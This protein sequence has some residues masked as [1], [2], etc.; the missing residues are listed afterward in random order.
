ME[1]TGLDIAAAA[2]TYDGVRFRN[3]GR[4][5][6]TGV[7]C[8]GLLLAV[9]RGFGLLAEVPDYAY[10]RR[11][12]GRLLRQELNKYLDIV[13]DPRAGDV[14]LFADK[15]SLPN[16]IGILT[17]D[18]HGLAIIHAHAPRK[19]VVRDQLSAEWLRK[20]RGLFA[21]PGVVR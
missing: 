8:L 21:I 6:E 13:N 16:H 17:P 4:S 3:Q 15:N 19:K 10:P 9:A 12:D 1:I 2:E 14:M 5:R 20:R 7:D 11:P 18:P